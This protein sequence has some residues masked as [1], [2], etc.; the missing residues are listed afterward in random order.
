VYACLILCT[1]IDLARVQWPQN[2]L[3]PLEPR[4]IT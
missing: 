3:N 2:P 4:A 1:F